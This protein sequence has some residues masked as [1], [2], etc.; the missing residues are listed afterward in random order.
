M[1]I[2][3]FND[4]QGFETLRTDWN[5]V[6]ARSR[7]NSLFLTWEW[8]TA[9]WECLGSGDLWL[10]AWYDTGELVA[11]APLYQTAQPDNTMELGTIGCAEVSDYLDLIIAEGYE[12]QVYQALLDW[13]AGPAAPKWDRLLLCNLPQDSLTHHLLPELAAGSGYQAVTV[14]EDVCPVIELPND[15]ETYMQ[16]HLSKKQRHEVRRK[17][18]RIQE[19]ATVAWYAVDGT[20]ELEH[21][22]AAFIRLHRFSTEE[23]HSFMTP[24]MQ[25]F[26]ERATQAMHRA[27]WLYL[28]FIEVNGVK[29]A[30]MLGFVYNDRLLVYNSGYDPT[31]YAEL[32]PGIVLTSHIIEDAIRRGMRIFDFLQG[33]EIYKY[34]FGAR[35]T[36]VYTTELWRS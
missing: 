34:R 10:L 14:L 12:Q 23:K 26:F 16:A 30:A 21:E 8:Q 31:N 33:D 4:A 36:V 1:D 29:A 7:S 27:G 3:V 9:W 25:A 17:V 35:D 24:E 20:H 13:L 18:R 28:A 19:E 11:I 22:T 5:L 32:S 6:L 15:F 2:R